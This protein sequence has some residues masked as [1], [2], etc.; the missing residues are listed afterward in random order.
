MKTKLV[1]I[2]VLF[3]A[4]QLQ[5]NAAVTVDQ[6]TSRDYLLKSGYSEAM[7]ESVSLGH[8]R[9]TGEEYYTEGEKRYMNDSKWVRFWKKA[10]AYFDPAA[11]DYSF[12]HHNI[13][14]VPDID[15]L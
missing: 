12:Y 11:E 13:E 4:L 10:Y 14:P 5:S 8:A 7:S 6:T 3:A 2:A 9:A 1:L 15:D